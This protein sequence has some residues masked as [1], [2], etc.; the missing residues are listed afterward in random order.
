MHLR[1]PREWLHFTSPFTITAL[2]KRLS[3]PGLQ[4]SVTPV[5]AGP[6]TVTVGSNGGER[7]GP[8]TVTVGSNGGERSGPLTVTVGSN[9]GERSGPLLLSAVTEVSGQVHCYCRQ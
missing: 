1:V 3:C 4:F 5:S 8:L 2:S 9:G 7:S 6:L